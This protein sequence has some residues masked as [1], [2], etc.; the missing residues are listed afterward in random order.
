MDLKEAQA[1]I[2]TEAKKVF[3][4]QMRPD[5][6]VL[7]AFVHD[8]RFARMPTLNFRLYANGTWEYEDG[9]HPG[10]AEPDPK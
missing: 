1:A 3:E 7:G 6:V 5:G 10:D 9:S 8:D 4:K 2:E